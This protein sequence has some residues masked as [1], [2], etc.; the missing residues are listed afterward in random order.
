MSEPYAHRARRRDSGAGGGRTI[1]SEM[2]PP[3]HS[4]AAAAAGYRGV[5]SPPPPRGSVPALMGMSARPGTG[6]MQPGPDGPVLDWSRDGVAFLWLVALI[7]GVV[8]RIALL[9]HGSPG[10]SG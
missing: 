1:K 7:L 4:G 6:F 8:V 10:V 3:P 5:M 9:A 2:T